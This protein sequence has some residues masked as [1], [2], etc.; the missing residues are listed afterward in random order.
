MPR[1]W[2]RSLHRQRR[3]HIRGTRGRQPERRLDQQ[4]APFGGHWRRPVRRTLLAGNNPPPFFHACEFTFLTRSRAQLRGECGAR[5]VKGAKIA[6]QHN[7]GL[8]GAG[9]VAV[10]ER[11]AFAEGSV[12][13]GGASGALGFGSGRSRM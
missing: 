2:R 10:Y 13:K 5:Q 11:P 7:I 12:R 8:G 6:L 1:G 3:Q 9:V 4:R